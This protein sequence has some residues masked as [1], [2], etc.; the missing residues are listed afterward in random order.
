M[1]PYLQAGQIEGI[2]GGL[3]GA[4]EYEKL[5]E[6]PGGGIVGMTAQSVGHIAIIIFIILGNIGY[7]AIR[8][9]GK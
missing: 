9:K 8:R 3:K 6:H 7:F 4:A 1:Y 5:V 2:I